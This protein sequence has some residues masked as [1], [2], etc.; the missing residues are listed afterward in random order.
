[1]IMK[2]EFGLI[3]AGQNNKRVEDNIQ[4]NLRGLMEHLLSEG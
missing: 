1:M 2:Q 4:Q 3:Y